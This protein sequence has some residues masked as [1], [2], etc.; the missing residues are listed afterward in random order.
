[1]SPLRLF[2]DKENRNR[3]SEPSEPSAGEENSHRNAEKLSDAEADG[4]LGTVSSTV[5]ADGTADAA[6][7]IVSRTV[8]PEPRIGMPN[9]A[10][11]DGTDGSDGVFPKLPKS[12]KTSMPRVLVRE[13]EEADERGLVARWSSEFGY[14]S[15]HDPLEGVWWDVSTK[16]A[17]SWAKS[18]ASRRKALYR[19]GN[20]RAYDLT[21]SQMERMWEAERA[22][23]PPDE[24]IVEDHPIEEADEQVG[25][26]LDAHRRGE[27]V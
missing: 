2:P 22:A 17:P 18:E 9:G 11:S 24:G 14:V 15:I 23:E 6:G 20:R 5:S 10:A 13:L 3:P 7:P 19:A 27:V 4:I 26:V 12:Q 8:S 21:S 16:D 25:E 1:V